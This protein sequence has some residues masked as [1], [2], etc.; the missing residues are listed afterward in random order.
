MEDSS[1]ET[2]VTSIDEVC[3]SGLKLKETTHSPPFAMG[4]CKVNTY[5]MH[6]VMKTS[7]EL[8]ADLEQLINGIKSYGAEPRVWMP[9][10]PILDGTT[11]YWVC[12][13]YI[14]GEMDGST[15]VHYNEDR[16]IVQIH[17]PIKKG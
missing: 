12:T 9:Q 8:L 11:G 17:A 13:V 1:N 4:K 10:K 5:P 6:V 7:D 2:P 15:F 3:V 14:L 16:Q